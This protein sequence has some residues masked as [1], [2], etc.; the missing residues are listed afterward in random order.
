VLSNPVRKLFTRVSPILLVLSVSLNVIQGMRL[1]RLGDVLAGQASVL[2]EGSLISSLDVSD[3]SGRTLRINLA[4][5]GLP[6]LL[7]VLRPTC[8]YCERNAITVNKLARQVRGRYQLVGLSLSTAGLGEFVANHHIEFPV[9]TGVSE[10]V[11]HEYG[12]NNTPE[13]ILVSP[14]GRVEKVWF[15]AYTDDV[16]VGIE[17]ALNIRLL[18]SKQQEVR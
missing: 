17:R 15:G 13:T 3:L 8:I 18:A 7:Y 9:Y 14:D 10:S 4:S 11:R 12:L 5:R 2:K 1:L 6:T 16:G